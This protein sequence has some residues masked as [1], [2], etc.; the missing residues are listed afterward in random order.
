MIASCNE[1]KIVLVLFRK[2]TVFV[3]CFL[4][5]GGGIKSQGIANLHVQSVF[6]KGM[7]KEER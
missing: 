2:F 3:F 7:F 1:R 5:G 4:I 6:Y